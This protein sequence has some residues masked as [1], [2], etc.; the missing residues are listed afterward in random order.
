MRRIFGTLVLLI[1]SI[2]FLENYV[3]LGTTKEAQ[4]SSRDGVQRIDVIVDSYSFEPDHIVVTANKPV[5]IDLKSVTSLIPHNFTINY[6]DAGLN[7]DE[8]IPHG[9]DLKVTFT[10]TKP[11]SYEFYCD[12]KFLFDSHKDKGMKGVLEVKP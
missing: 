9:K 1:L 7:V 4:V 12:K 6:P 2:L 8:D 10:P 3:A 5:E 11:G